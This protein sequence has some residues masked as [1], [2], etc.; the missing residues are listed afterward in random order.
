MGIKFIHENDSET[1]I[2]IGSRK[3][4]LNNCSYKAK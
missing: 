4:I 1:K 3:K 2:K